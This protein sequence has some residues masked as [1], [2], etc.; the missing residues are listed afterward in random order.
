MLQ[1]F[2]LSTSDGSI[3]DFLLFA[4]GENGIFEGGLLE[5]YFSLVLLV[6]ALDLT[7][8]LLLLLPLLALTLPPLL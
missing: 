8:P 2:I 5:L 3:S 6:L 1:L 7:L 4:F